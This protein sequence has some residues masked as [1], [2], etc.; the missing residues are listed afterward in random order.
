VGVAEIKTKPTKAS[1]AAYIATIADPK[2]R[3]ECQRVSAMMRAVTKASPEMWGASMVGFGR[4]NMRYASGREVEW[5][6]M[7]F[8]SRKAAISLYLTCDLDQFA[9]LLEKLGRHER[10][11]GCLYVKTLD[12]VD[13]KVLGQLFR[14]SAKAA[15]DFSRLKLGGESGLPKGIGNPAERALANAG[16]TSLAKIARRSEEELLGMHGVGPKAVGIIKKALAKQG[17]KLAGK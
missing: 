1:A 12:D 3:A 8:S 11:V 13:L 17:K 14:A 4:L 5:L 15:K 7:G 9:P 10:G 2:R 16:I 6:V